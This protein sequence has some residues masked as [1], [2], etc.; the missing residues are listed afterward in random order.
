MGPGI[1]SVHAADPSDRCP[2]GAGKLDFSDIDFEALV[3]F[4]SVFQQRPTKCQFD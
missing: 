2:G 4:S 3:S 1:K